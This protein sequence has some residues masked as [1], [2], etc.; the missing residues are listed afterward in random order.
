MATLF[1]VSGD[2]LLCY[3]ASKANALTVQSELLCYCEEKTRVRC[4]QIKDNEYLEQDEEI[5]IKSYEVKLMEL[6]DQLSFL[7]PSDITV[8]IESFFSKV[9]LVWVIVE[10]IPRIFEF[11]EDFQEA[12]HGGLHFERSQKYTKYL[13]TQKGIFD[14]RGEV[15]PAR[16]LILS[17]VSPVSMNAVAIFHKM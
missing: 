4:L 3:L 8:L 5:E 11:R 16:T 6:T 14:Y 10:N 9:E 7:I 15:T 1:E 12:L 2:Y 17:C 13:E